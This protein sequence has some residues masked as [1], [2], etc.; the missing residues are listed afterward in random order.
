MR[1]LV[2]TGVATMDAKIVDAVSKPPWR[3][4]RVR[5]GERL[6]GVVL[7]VRDAA[8]M[9]AIKN[10][11]GVLPPAGHSWVRQID[12]ELSAELRRQLFRRGDVIQVRVT[13][14]DPTGKSHTLALEQDPLVQGAL[15]AMDVGSGHVLAMVGGYDFTKSQFN[16]A[17]QS[18]RQPGSAFTPLI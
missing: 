9:V 8:A 4:P 3:G 12:P 5:E 18:L 11:R 15:L 17:V 7:A 6:P 10:T 16:R 1:R 14:V 2:D 13:R